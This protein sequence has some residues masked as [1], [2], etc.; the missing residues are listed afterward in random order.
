MTGSRHSTAGT[1]FEVYADADQ[2]GEALA[3]VILDGVASLPPGRRYL[4]GCPGRP[5]PALHVPGT[6]PAGPGGR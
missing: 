5:Q 6:G 2:L 1:P 4:L 3:R